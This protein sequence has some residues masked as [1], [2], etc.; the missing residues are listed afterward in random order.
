MTDITLA[1]GLVARAGFAYDAG[2]GTPRQEWLGP[3]RQTNR[4][5]DQEDAGESSP[6]RLVG[7]KVLAQ[8]VG[9]T[10]R[11]RQD[12]A[13]DAADA[14]DTA[15]AA[16]TSQPA[17]PPATLIGGMPQLRSTSSSDSSYAARAI[18]SFSQQL[19]DSLTAKGT[20]INTYA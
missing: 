11:N 20:R 2:S 6:L 7:H 15:D 14:V 16:D 12:P 18:A 19:R 1:A 3:A 10:G 8:G 5:T 9:R 13:A 17:Q 4:S